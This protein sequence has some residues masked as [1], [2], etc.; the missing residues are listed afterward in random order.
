M[1]DPWKYKGLIILVSK[2]QSWDL[3]QEE[4]SAG[5]PSTALQGPLVETGIHLMA[6]Q[7]HC[8]EKWCSN[9]KIKGEQAAWVFSYF[10]ESSNISNIKLHFS[11]LL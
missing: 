3:N 1:S 5:A 4:D 11:A 8:Q 10:L 6:P 7:Q 9:P 2:T